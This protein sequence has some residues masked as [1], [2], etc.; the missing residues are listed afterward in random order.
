MEAPAAPAQREIVVPAA[1]ATLRLSTF[2]FQ[3]DGSSCGALALFVIEAWEAYVEQGQNV[4]GGFFGYLKRCVWHLARAGSR[5]NADNAQSDEDPLG[6]QLRDLLH[7]RALSFRNTLPSVNDSGGLDFH[8]KIAAPVN[9]S[10]VF[11]PALKTPQQKKRRRPTSPAGNHTSSRKLSA[12]KRL[13]S[14]DNSEMNAVE[15]LSVEA[16]ATRFTELKWQ[17]PVW[18]CCSCA[19]LWMKKSLCGLS[20]CDL[21]AIQVDMR[22]LWRGLECDEFDGCL[23]FCS[24]CA[25]DISAKCVPRHHDLRGVRFPHVPTTV[26][27]LNDIE[28]RLVAPNLAFGRFVSLSG[29]MYKS[30]VT[31]LY[32]DGQLG[33]HGKI[34]NVPTKLLAVQTQLPRL[35]SETDSCFVGIVRNMQRFQNV[36]WQGTVRPQ[37]VMK[38]LRELTVTPLYVK[39]GVRVREG[40]ERMTEAEQRTTTEIEQEEEDEEGTVPEYC[41]APDERGGSDVEGDDE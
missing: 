12:A 37:L 5:T 28:A 1:P 31:N 23:R 40:W 35:R 8:A 4:Q 25:H 2:R 3:T 24:T 32:G 20:S 29:A 21:E 30:K 10:F 27:Q 7:A 15:S 14:H 26:Q 19:R 6:I 11:S 22:E 18:S 38:A 17:A 9:A 34:V 41:V 16:V 33:L 39:H 36:V 13:I